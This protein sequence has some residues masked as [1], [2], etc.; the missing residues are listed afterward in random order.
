MK[1]LLLV[2]HAK[3]SWQEE[4]LQDRC[5]PLN[6]RGQEQLEPLHRALLRSGALG[7]DIYSSD[8]NRARSTLAGIVPPQFPEN[9]IHIDA[10]LYT[11]D[12]QQLLGWLKSLDDKQDT[13]TII[14]HNP[15]LLE[16]ACHLLKH[17][18][19]RLPTAGILSIVFPDKPWRKLAKSKG[20]GKL[21][22]FLTPRDYSYREFSRKSRKR[23]AAKGEEPA[24]NLQAELQHQLKRLR[25]LESGVRTGLDDEFLH[26]FRIAI[27]RS[28]A[29]AE[30]LLDVTDN[31]TLAKASKPLKR[32]AART[33]ELRDLHVFLQDLPNL[34]QGNDELHSALGTWAQGEAEKAHHAV[35]EHL[36]S[37]SYRTDMHDWEDF[38]HSGTLKKLAARMQTEDIRR[39]VR[40]RLEGFNRLTAETLHDSPDED[41]HRLR[42]QL[43]RIRY[44][45][46]LDAQNW[47]S[48][49]KNLKYRQELYGR[50]QDLCVQIDLVHQFQDQA[51]ETMPAAIQNLMEYL[52]G[53]KTDTRR[54]ILS[55]GG[56]GINQTE[57]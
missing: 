15:A 48:A 23:V 43:K 56:L 21:E 10:A 20:K 36:D 8:A 47:K 37:K 51:P 31:K 29:I 34:C 49:L 28:R 13:V 14:G 45:M 25:D 26:Q 33:S 30:A 4:G 46:E 52:R 2:R 9:R 18:P 19:A 42:K 35:V 12:C 11:F 22:A 1:H 3:S 7:G 50:F 40:N 24:K 38:I 39:A 16:L 53:A 41:I 55:L 5:R 54:Q 32:H 17:P 27:R 57:R 44:L 6:N